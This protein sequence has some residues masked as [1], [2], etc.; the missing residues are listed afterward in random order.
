MRRELVPTLNWER[1]VTPKILLRFDNP[2]TRGGTGNSEV[3]AK[4]GTLVREIDNLQGVSNGFI[5]IINYRGSVREVL[6]AGDMFTLI[7]ERDDGRRETLDRG[8]LVDS[9]YRFLT[10]A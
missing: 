3:H 4:Y 2:K 6:A 1:E 5:E 9:L 7:Y 10:Q 8:A